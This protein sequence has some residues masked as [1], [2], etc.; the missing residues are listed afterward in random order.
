MGLVGQPGG[1]L[2]WDGFGGPRACVGR[3]GFN[4]LH[5]SVDREGTWLAA[6]ATDCMLNPLAPRLCFFFEITKQK[7][8]RPKT[9]NATAAL[10]FIKAKH[11]DCHTIPREGEP[12]VVPR[13]RLRKVL[14]KEEAEGWMKVVF[15]L[16]EALPLV[17]RVLQVRPA[18][19]V[20]P[21]RVRINSNTPEV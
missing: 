10:L 20:Q 6:G 12:A 4:I 21:V 2:G 8:T 19:R 1:R 18:L 7:K 16:R 5:A 15:H 11:S 14:Q 17:R 3:G 13:E 9:E